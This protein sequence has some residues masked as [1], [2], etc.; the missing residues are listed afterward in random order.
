[1]AAPVRLGSFRRRAILWSRLSDPR[2]DLSLEGG[3]V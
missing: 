1:V 3:W 2:S